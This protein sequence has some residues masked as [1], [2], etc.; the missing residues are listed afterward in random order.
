MA[1]IYLFLGL[2]VI[3]LCSIAFCINEIHREQKEQQASLA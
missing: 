1:L 3:S 2:I